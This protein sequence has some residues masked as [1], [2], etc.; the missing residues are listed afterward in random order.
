MAAVS[1]PSSPSSKKGRTLSPRKPL[2][3]CTP[4]RT[5][6]GDTETCRFHTISRMI[7][8]LVFDPLLGDM[9]ET[10][11][12][13]Y[14]VFMPLKTPMPPEGTYSVEKCSE[15]GYLKIMLFYYF[16]HLAQNVDDPSIRG[17]RIQELLRMPEIPQVDVHLFDTLKARMKSS[18]FGYQVQLD[19]TELLPDILKKAINPLLQL[20]FYIELGLET[21]ITEEYDSDDETGIPPGQHIV[22][23][24]GSEEAQG[25][26]EN[27]NLVV[28]KNSW[29]GEESKVPFEEVI[30]LE[31]ESFSVVDLFFLLPYDFGKYS[32][33]RRNMEELYGLLAQIPHPPPEGGKKRK[34]KYGQRR[35]HHQSK[36]I[37]ASRKRTKTRYKR[38]LSKY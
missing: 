3:A 17:D 8:H 24:V 33:D 15:K 25:A 19:N 30:L 38:R 11:L 16:F 20:G 13:K 1:P 36:T 18:V 35:N 10:E 12:E 4:T 37:R 31:D 26:E 21:V 28:I 32:F 27:V 9:N 23:I 7:I 2:S 5:D 34:T 29:G 6:Q 22:L 14:R